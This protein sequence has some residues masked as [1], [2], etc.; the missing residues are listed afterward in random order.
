MPLVLPVTVFS[1]SVF[2]R[3]NPITPMPKSSGRFRVAIPARFVQPDPAVVAD[4]SYAAAGEPRRRRAVPD[5]HVALDDG[6]RTTWPPRRCRRAV[7]GRRDALDPGAGRGGDVDPGS[8]GTLDEPGALNRDV[9]PSAVVMPNSAG[10]DGAAAPG[11]RV[12]LAG[13]GVAVEPQLDAWRP[14]REAGP[15]RSRRR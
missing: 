1:S 7:G 14:E 10:G 3:P 8:C 4:D 15:R 11:D 12:G 2:L 5:G 6:C 13:D 9:R